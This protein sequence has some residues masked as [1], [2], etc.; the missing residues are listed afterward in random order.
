MNFNHRKRTA[1]YASH[2]N[3]TQV[4]YEY[5]TCIKLVQYFAY[6]DSFDVISSYHIH[7][8]CFSAIMW[9]KFCEMFT[10]VTSL[11]Y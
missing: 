3:R 11:S 9:G 5:C 10:I 4:D 1:V 2:Q 6:K 7:A 8:S